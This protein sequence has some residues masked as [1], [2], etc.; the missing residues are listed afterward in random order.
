MLWPARRSCLP[1]GDGGV[2]RVITRRYRDEPVVLAV[3]VDGVGD[4]A[5]TEL[6]ERA[7]LARISLA[8]VLVE[9]LDSIAVA[10]DEGLEAAAGVD[11]AELVVVADDDGLGP[12]H[13][14]GGEELE[15]GPVVGHAGFVDQ[16]HG[17]VVEAQVA[18]FEAPDEGG[19]GA[20]VDAGLVVE[21]A[22]GLAADGGA[23]DSVAAGF[24][25]GPHHL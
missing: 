3:P 25:G 21:G 7:S 2:Q 1:R 13:V 5:A 10:A 8:D 23:E 18:V 24:V 20:A 12:G 19:D 22:G 17:A 6:L 14:D 16:H 9:N 15:Q 4:P 11:G